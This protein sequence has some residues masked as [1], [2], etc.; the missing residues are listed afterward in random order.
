M[1]LTLKFSLVHDSVRDGNGVGDWWGGKA[2]AVVEE[3][4]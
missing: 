3:N 1:Q 2:V 4:N